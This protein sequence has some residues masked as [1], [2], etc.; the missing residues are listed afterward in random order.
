[1]QEVLLPTR[2]LPV[3]YTLNGNFVHFGTKK[4]IRTDVSFRSVRSSVRNFTVSCFEALFLICKMSYMKL[5]LFK[6][7]EETARQLESGSHMT[8]PRR[9]PLKLQPCRHWQD[10]PMTEKEHRFDYAAEM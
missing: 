10:D 7:S 5:G 6:K 4:E 9:R 3:V 8:F 2:F 1:M